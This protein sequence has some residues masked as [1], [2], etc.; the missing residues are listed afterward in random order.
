MDKVGHDKFTGWDLDEDDS[1]SLRE[2][3]FIY[4][5]IKAVQELSAEINK[6]KGE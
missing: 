3:Q 5:L 1:Q 2:G 4:P 6:L